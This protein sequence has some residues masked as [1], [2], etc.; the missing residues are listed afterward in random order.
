MS[1]VLTIRPDRRALKLYFGAR[2]VA[3][4]VLGIVA[5]L[6]V[7]SKLMAAP[8]FAIWVIFITMCWQVACVPRTIPLRAWLKMH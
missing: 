1:D 7:P 2:M 6:L 3:F 5:L 8:F 4:L